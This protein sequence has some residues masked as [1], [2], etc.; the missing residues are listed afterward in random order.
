MILL[1]VLK[2]CVYPA[3]LMYLATL[4]VQLYIR[5]DDQDVVWKKFFGFYLAVMNWLFTLILVC[6]VSYDV[7]MSAAEIIGGTL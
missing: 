3:I 6:W 4:G 1:F 2:V 7:V 5:A